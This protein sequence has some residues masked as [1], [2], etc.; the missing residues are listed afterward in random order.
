M[1]NNTKVCKRFGMLLHGDYLVDA[2]VTRVADALAAEGFE[3]HV[4]CLLVISVQVSFDISLSLL[5]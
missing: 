2:R 5:P 3:V 1:E 4:V